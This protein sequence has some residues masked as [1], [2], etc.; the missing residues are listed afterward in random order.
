[1]VLLYVV[2]LLEEYLGE[3]L[4]NSSFL[5]EQQ[6]YGKIQEVLTS[7]MLTK[8]MDSMRMNLLQQERVEVEK[9]KHFVSYRSMIYEI[10]LLYEV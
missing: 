3:I 2:L 7:E 6:E 10:L 5:M 9:Q 4:D 1:M 8:S